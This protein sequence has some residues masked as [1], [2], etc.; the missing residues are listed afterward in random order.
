MMGFKTLIGVI[1]PARS[2]WRRMSSA[3]ILLFFVVGCNLNKAGNLPPTNEI[4]STQTGS[5]WYSV[6]FTQPGAPNAETL[7][8]GPD[9]ALAEAIREANLG[10]DIA[11]DT[12]DL[13][14]IRDALIDADRRGVRVRAVVESD[15]LDEPEVQDLVQVGIEVLGDRREGM[16]HNKFAI[17]D[18]QEVWTGSMNFTLNGAYRSDNNLIRIRSARLAEDY[19]VEFEEMFV[20]DQF[21]PGSPADTPYAKLQIEST[22]AE[23][24]FSPDDGTQQRLYE[25]ISEAKQSVS[26]LAYSFT[27]DALVEA[28][29]ERAAAGVTIAGVLDE[30]QALGNQGGEYQR[31]LESGLDVRLDGNPVTMHHKVLIIDDRIVVTGSYNFSQNAETRND[32]NT[33]ILYSPEIAELYMA[34]FERVF[35]LAEQY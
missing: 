15:N 10:V 26:F 22:P 23:V 11:M 5:G 9:S 12:L 16:M 13:W 14:S 33:L 35:E 21:G 25:L 34:E 6:Y 20:D 4:P 31:M 7:R 30:S 3:L 1:L 27:S 17:L 2:T 28:I 19:L 29:L 32:E 8:G 24:Y 18:R